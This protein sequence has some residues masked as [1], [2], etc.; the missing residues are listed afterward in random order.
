M[1]S[2]ITTA[3]L[4]VLIVFT[5]VLTGAASTFAQTP[6]TERPAFSLTA[7]AGLSLTSGNTDTSMINV[8][9]EVVVNPEGRNLIKSDGLLLRGKN[10]DQLTAN[11]V[12]VTLRDQFQFNHRAYGFV[13]N[14]YLADTFK[15]IDYFNAPT[16][17]AGYTVIDSPTTRLSLE[18][19][20]GVVGEKRTREE[21]NPW[22]CLMGGESLTRTLTPT[23]TITQWFSG[24]LKTK[25]VRDSL[26][27]LATDISATIS[28]RS[29]L[30]IEVVD[31][32]RNRTASAAVEKNDVALIVAFVYKM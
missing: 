13:Q 25:D 4:E 26:Y 19:G 7:S 20:I 12:S 30:K 21:M 18:A 14:Q 16:T 15:E 32:F 24:I 9:Y 27:T 11:R 8:A 23:T 2:Y 3:A 22:L 17:G 28:A 1:R 31:T 6:P 5:V 29:Q 10:E